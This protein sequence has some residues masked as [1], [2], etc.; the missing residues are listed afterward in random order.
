MADLQRV[1]QILES[2]G[3]PHWT[4]GKNVNPGWVNIQCPFCNDPSNH[5]G[6]FPESLKINCWRCGPQGN[7][8]SALR[9]LTGITR[10]EYD[11][12]T[13]DKYKVNF[14]KSALKQVKAVLARRKEPVEEKEE[15]VPRRIELPEEAKLITKDTKSPLLHHY[16]TKIR[17]N[18]ISMDTLIKHH[19]H[20]CTH[21]TYMNRMI[22]PVYFERKLIAFQA[23]DLTG[24]AELKYKTEGDI[25]IVLYGLDDI[26][27]GGRIVLTEGILDAW[28]LEHDVVCSFGTHLT[29]EQEQLIRDKKPS[30]LVFAWDSDAY[31]KARKMA[32]D[33]VRHVPKIRV[34]RFPFFEDPDSYGYTKTW[35]LIEKEIASDR[36]RQAFGPREDVQSNSRIQQR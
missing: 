19:C 34:V 28:R 14:Q 7:L 16:L 23:A 17:K 13:K 21:G 11:I 2:Y 33:F 22:I 24:Q 20:L 8:Y 3:I 27:E 31:F 15:R 6:I 35:E 1:V 32:G 26:R 25:N 4:Q 30:V 5:L 36:A 12:L 29:D 18:P 9:L 10:A